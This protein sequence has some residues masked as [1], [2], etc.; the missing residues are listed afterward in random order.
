MAKSGSMS[1]PKGMYS[2][3]G[4]PMKKPKMVEGIGPNSNPDAQKAAKLLKKAHAERDSLR[5][6]SGM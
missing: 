5:G 1:S 4:N 2:S 6:K 3:K